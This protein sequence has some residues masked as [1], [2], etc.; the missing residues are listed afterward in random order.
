MSPQTPTLRKWLTLSSQFDVDVY[1]TT[2]EL[3]A[4]LQ[5]IIQQKKWLRWNIVNGFEGQIS[6]NGFRIQPI[7]DYSAAD[8]LA[9]SMQAVRVHGRFEA[10]GDGCRVHVFIRH[11]WHFR[12]FT[13]MTMAI[14]VA[15][16]VMLT[17][18]L[19]GFGDFDNR[20]RGSL[21]YGGPVTLLL[22]GYFWYRIL[23]DIRHTEVDV[24]SLLTSEPGN[25]TDGQ[26]S[27]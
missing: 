19:L 4:R 9:K 8:A 24:V 13:W 11:G 3:A 1:E 7:N 23:R 22:L 16:V 6:E 27:S 21:T 25:E 5:H 12:L 15:M 18:I 17:Q 20:E 2:Q 10:S 14:M 26:R